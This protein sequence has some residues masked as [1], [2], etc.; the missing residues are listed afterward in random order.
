[1]KNSVLFLLTILAC[2]FSSLAYAEPKWQVE[3]NIIGTFQTTDQRQVE[4]EGDL[5]A[6]LLVTRQL[7]KGALHLHLEGVSTPNAK[8][9][10]NYFPDANAD[11]GTALDKHGDGRIQISELFYQSEFSGQHNLAIGYLDITGFFEQSRIASD[12]TTQFISVPFK[13]NPTIEFPDYSI[14]G[15]YENN[16]QNA[17]FFRLGVSSAKGLADTENRTY[18]EL[19]SE[20]DQGLFAVTSIS[21]ETEQTLLRAGAWINTSDH[22][23]LN[24][25]ATDKSN[26]GLYLLGE[27]NHQR[28]SVGGRFGYANESVSEMS[29][30]ISMEYDYEF[31]RFEFGLA[32]AFSL[33]SSQVKQAQKDDSQIGEF[34]VRYDLIPS[35]LLLTG[36]LQYIENSEFI[37]RKDG[38]VYGARLSWL[39]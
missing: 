36:H 31:D 2:G 18:S 30:F 4:N 6:N 14:A 17:L 5:R 1:M 21:Q 26:Y 35:E 8:G 29:Q 12:E 25:S 7:P 27:Y 32:Y 37:K 39:F 34:F 9:V 33:L 22:A 24:G 13:G 38:Q 15:V 16:L 28:H 11:V 23:E 19:F 20:M 3:G 10:S